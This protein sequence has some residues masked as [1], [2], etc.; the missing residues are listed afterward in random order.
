MLTFETKILRSDIFAQ[1]I[2]ISVTPTLQNLRIGH[3]KRRIGK[4]DVPVEAGQKYSENKRSNKNLNYVELEIL[5]SSKRPTTIITV[6]CSFNNIG[7]KMSL[8]IKIISALASRHTCAIAHSTENPLFPRPLLQHTLHDDG[9]TYQ[10][11]GH[12]GRCAST[13]EEARGVSCTTKGEKAGDPTL[14][15]GTLAVQS[16]VLTPESDIL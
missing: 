8:F 3:K 12:M 11:G 5:T 2:L 7:I 14:W 1:V 4:S 16:V 13:E 10:T 6:R 15:P 9:Q